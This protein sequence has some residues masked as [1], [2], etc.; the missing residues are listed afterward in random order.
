MDTSDET[1]PQ[2]APSATISLMILL[3]GVTL[4]FGHGIFADFVWDDK[5][6]ILDNPWM[7]HNMTPFAAWSNDFWA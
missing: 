5:S 1:V 7:R 3:V 2:W 6:L 4:T